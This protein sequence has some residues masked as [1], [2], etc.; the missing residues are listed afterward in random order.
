MPPCGNPIHM[1]QLKNYIAA[2]SLGTYVVFKLGNFFRAK[3]ITCEEKVELK[4][5]A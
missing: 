3:I 1:G 4:R 2:I 5:G